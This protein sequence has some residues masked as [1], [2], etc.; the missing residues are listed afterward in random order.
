MTNERQENILEELSKLGY[1]E[2]KH[3]PDNENV[4][5][6]VFQQMMNDTPT[7]IIA[8]DYTVEL[9]MR[10]SNF[11]FNEGKQIMLK[12]L[13]DADGV[14]DNQTKVAFLLILEKGISPTMVTIQTV[15]SSLTKVSDNRL[16]PTILYS[17]QQQSRIRIFEI[18]T[19]LLQ[20]SGKS[21]MGVTLNEKNVQS[22]H[23]EALRQAK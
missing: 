3:L 23:E 11:I 14:K 22:A 13:T 7:V 6:F 19:R 12:Y 2:D 21:A 18:F 1:I 5:F 15:M 8:I 9:T 20:K 17:L 10:N 16:R 4:R